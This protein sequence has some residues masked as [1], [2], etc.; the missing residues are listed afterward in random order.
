MAGLNYGF[1][2]RKRRGKLN[3]FPKKEGVFYSELSK[4]WIVRINKGGI[5]GMSSVGSAKTEEEANK[6]YL[7]LKQNENKND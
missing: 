6:L 4:K 3:A 5:I 2:Y 1:S 7:K